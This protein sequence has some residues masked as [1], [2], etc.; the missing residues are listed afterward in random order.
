MKS[1]L[2]HLVTAL[3]LSLLMPPL[4]HS[5]T[6]RF[7]PEPPPPPSAEE[8][9]LDGKEKQKSDDDALKAA[10]KA[11]KDK[12]AKKVSKAARIAVLNFG[13]PSQWQDKAGKTVGEHI[14]AQAWNEAFDM[15]VKDNVDIVVVRV[16]SDGGLGL[17]VARFHDVLR[18]YRT[19]FR[20]VAWI[21]SAIS[22][23]AMAPWV[24]QEFYMMP[25]G[26]IGACTGH[27]G[28]RAA[29]EGVPLE[30]ALIQMEQA[31]KV[32]SR[33]PKIMRSMQV[34][35]PLSAIIDA[36]GNVKWFQDVSGEVV[37]QPG[38]ILTFNSRDAVKYKFALGIASN[39]DE[40]AKA[41]GVAEWEPAGKSA[42]KYIDTSLIEN[43]KAEK[44]LPTIM[45]KYTVCVAGAQALA[46]RASRQ[47]EV[48]R[49]KRFLNDLER[50]VKKNKNFGL[51]NN[52][53]PDWFRDQEDLLKWL[54]K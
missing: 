29:V 54:L 33:D 16:N 26:N 35:E 20:T 51:L 39:L 30:Q 36:N 9:E 49:A 48:G 38:H 53:T 13:P 47:V 23:A 45:D 37:N 40:L 2:F 32:A 10:E 18:K 22:A 8:R 4:A 1:R 52:L 11:N 50:I 28:G 27:Y 3:S 25:Q 14:V 15:L 43:T 41:M 19:K 46:D 44:D 7:D 12:E 21:E 5:S 17:E 6:V 34:E 31:S 42:E 24:L